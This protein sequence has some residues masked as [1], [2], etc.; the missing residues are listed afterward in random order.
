MSAEGKL[1]EFL[2]QWRTVGDLTK[3]EIQKLCQNEEGIQEFVKELEIEADI[4]ALDICLQKDDIDRWEQGVP[5]LSMAIYHHLKDHF[6]CYVYSRMQY[7]EERKRKWEET[8]KE[9]FQGEPPKIYSRFKLCGDVRSEDYETL[10]KL[11][12]GKGSEADDA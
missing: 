8:Y 1:G 2:Q 4:L 9:L 10:F 5:T 3:D 11:C 12:T 6:Q 7:S